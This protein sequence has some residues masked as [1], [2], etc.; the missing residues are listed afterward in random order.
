MP[1]TK[2][3]LLGPGFIADIHIESYENGNQTMVS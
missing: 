1:K 3:A 2:I